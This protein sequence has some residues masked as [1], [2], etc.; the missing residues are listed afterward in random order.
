VLARVKLIAEPWDLG[1]YEAG[2][3]PVDW[4]EWNGRFRDTVRRFFKGDPGQLRDLGWRITGSADLYGDD[5]RSAYNS[6][7]FVTCHDGLTLRD[8]VSY[9]GKHNE[10]NLEANRDGTDANHSWNCGAEGKTDDPDIG[11]LRRRMAK[12]L[13]CGLLFSCGTPMLLG[14]DEFL[15]TQRG[16]NNAYCQDNELSWFDW[17]D[18]ARNADFVEFTRRAIGF[19]RR[20]PVLQRRK[21]L[22]GRDLDADG[23]PD[24]RWQGS[25]GSG[26][27]W[28][29]PNERTIAYRLASGRRDGRPGEDVLFFVLNADWNLRP[30]R[31]PDAPEGRRWHRIVD[32]SLDAPDDFLEEE[33]AIP[34][35]PED[36][37]LVNPRSVIVL[38]AR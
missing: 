27:A 25:D 8:L 16:N 20:Y 37:Y 28:D 3:F 24:I 5:G 29:D 17:R 10:A 11:R 13:M 35:A 4:S 14:G 31:L 21:F 12:N 30:V 23:L 2:N 32:T 33:R 34:L 15:R 9:D 6:I 36:H 7:N 22:L 1:A 26:P 19:T 18:A 38:L